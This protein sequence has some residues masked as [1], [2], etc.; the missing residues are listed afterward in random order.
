MQTDVTTPS[1]IVGRIQP[2]RLC[3]PCVMSVRG[4]NNFGRAVQTNPTL[5]RYA[6]AITEQNKCWELLGEKFDQ[7]Q[8]LCN[9]SQQHPTTC[10]RVCK[11]TQHVTFNSVGS[12]WSTMMRPFARVLKLTWLDISTPLLVFFTLVE[13]FCTKKEQVNISRSQLIK[14]KQTHKRG[15]FNSPEI[16]QTRR[17][18]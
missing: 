17:R 9:N 3:K 4:P 7:F 6:S 11:R 18:R 10:N 5:L 1:C 12:C 2:I 13:M 16:K 8:T 14:V 15:L